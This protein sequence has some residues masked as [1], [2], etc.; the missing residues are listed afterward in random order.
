MLHSAAA[1]ATS[2]FSWSRYRSPGEC[3][4]VAEQVLL[5]TQPGWAFA[6]LR[7]LRARGL[8][9]HV[10]FHHRDSSLVATAHE[11]LVAQ[12]LLTPEDVYGL[13]VA[14]E[15]PARFDATERLRPL[16]HPDRLKKEM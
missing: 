14:A 9:S 7:E 6:T 1:P 13:V 10:A 16:F 2:W 4:R 11:A 12:P 8:R 15:G 3:V 5:T